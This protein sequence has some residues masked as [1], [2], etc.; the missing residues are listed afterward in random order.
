MDDYRLRSDQ[1]ILKRPC[2]TCGCRAY[3]G[4]ETDTPHERFLRRLAWAVDAIGGVD[5]RVRF[6]VANGDLALSAIEVVPR[7]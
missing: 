7:G 5:L 6:N 3:D 4:D 2:P 1:S